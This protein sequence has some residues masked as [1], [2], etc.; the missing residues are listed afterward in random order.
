MVM[1]RKTGFL[2]TLVFHLLVVF[3]I[4]LF[5]FS[6]PLPLP[7]E[8]GILINFGTD[9]TGSG[10]LEPTAAELDEQPR[11]AQP[12]PA[13]P[14]S[15]EAEEE[16]LTQDFEEAPAEEVQITPVEKEREK[17]PVTAPQDEK[18]EPKPEEVVPEPVEEPREVNEK[19]LYKGRTNTGNTESGEG[20]TSGQGN[21][22]SIT[23]TENAENYSNALSSGSGSVS[24]SLSGRNPLVLPKPEYDHQKEGK[25]VVEVTVDRNGNVVRTNPGVRGST[26]LDEY[27]LKV[28]NEAALKAKFDRKPDAPAYQ[29]G[30]ITYIFVLQ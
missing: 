27:L 23:G 30:T 11:P 26:T 17:Q 15:E 10:T 5:G 24:Y 2:G 1:F 14:A 25:V 4:A 9:E 19:A 28:A 3:F 8:E 12:E 18:T 20:I 16:I 13:S 22:G 6:T 7:E 21:Q 29:K